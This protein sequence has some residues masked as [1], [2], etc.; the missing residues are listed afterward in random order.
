MNSKLAILA[1]VA[2]VFT[3]GLVNSAEAS[4]WGE[5]QFRIF[6]GDGSGTGN[7]SENTAVAER[8]VL[9]PNSFGN[10]QSPVQ[11]VCGDHICKS[12][13]Q[14]PT[15]SKFK[16]YGGYTERKHINTE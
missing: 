6:I 1:L 7:V 5:H 10:F 8:S 11:T 12:G 4:N 16:A 2:M 15:L 13:E 9:K 3:V 14:P